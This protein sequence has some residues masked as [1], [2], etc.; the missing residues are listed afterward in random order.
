MSRSV[1]APK[2]AGDGELQKKGPRQQ[3]HDEARK[4]KNNAGSHEDR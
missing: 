2:D 1:A 4:D 3:A